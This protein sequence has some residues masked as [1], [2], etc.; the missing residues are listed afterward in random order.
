MRVRGWLEPRVTHP[1]GGAAGR[2]AYPHPSWV[3]LKRLSQRWLRMSR[4]R[5]DR[6]IDRIDFVV[7]LIES[8]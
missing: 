2:M 7:L 8:D 5:L 4:A 6:D 1:R 3:I